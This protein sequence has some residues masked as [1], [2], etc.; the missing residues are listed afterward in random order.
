MIRVQ[1]RAEYPAFDTQ[2]R[3]R[4]QRFLERQPEPEFGGVQE[5]QL[6]V[7]SVGALVCCV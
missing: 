5:T 2:V 1:P 3:Q 6:L 7:G 4:G